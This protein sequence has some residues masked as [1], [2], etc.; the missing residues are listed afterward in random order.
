MPV[1][2]GD[3]YRLIV[4]DYGAVDFNNIVV[5]NVIV[6]VQFTA[7]SLWLVLWSQMLSVIGF[8]RPSSH[9]H[10]KRAAA[11]MTAVT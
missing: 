2:A 5:G 6:F 9:C 11:E 3:T 10:R 1:P 4:F 8:E 7:F